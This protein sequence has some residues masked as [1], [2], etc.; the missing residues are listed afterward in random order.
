MNVGNNIHVPSVNPVGGKCLHVPQ[1]AW[2]IRRQHDFSDYTVDNLPIFKVGLPPR[3]SR[4]KR[5]L[6][7]IQI[8]PCHHLD[9]GVTPLHRDLGESHD[10]AWRIGD[11]NGIERLASDR[12]WSTTC[13]YWK[14]PKIALGLLWFIGLKS[15]RNRKYVGLECPA[16]SNPMG[17][18]ISSQSPAGTFHELQLHVFF[19]WKTH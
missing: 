1:P 14:A 7:R 16:K 3:P 8:P 6:Q 9:S 13:T 5:L 18:G 2:P 19:L 11:V 17:K 12:G 4:R 15:W 10:H